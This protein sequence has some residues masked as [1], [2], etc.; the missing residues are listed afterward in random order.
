MLTRRDFLKAAAAGGAGLAAMGLVGCSSSSSS[1]SSTSSSDS[2]SESTGSTEEASNATGLSA[3]PSSD[4]Y[5]GET[6]QQT[7][8]L[9]DEKITLTMWYPIGSSMGTLADLNDGEFWQWYEELTNVHIEFTVPATGSESDAFNLLFASGDMPDI[10]YS[11]PDS[12]TYRGGQDAAIEDG[13]FIDMAE[14]L[15]YAPNYVSWLNSHDEYAKAAYS[16]TGKL[17]GFWGAWQTDE[18]TTYADQGISIRQDFLDAVN[19]EIPT[20]YDEWEEVLAAFRDE[21]G[22]EAPFYTGKYGIDNGEFMAGFDTAPYFYQRDGVVNYGPMDDA[23]KEY[24]EMLHRWW[25]EG[26][27]DPDFAT[28]ASTGIMAD[29]DMILNDKVGALVD[30]GT[31]MGSTY[32]TRGATNENFNAVAALQPKM[33]ADSVDP[34]WRYIAVGSERMTGQA[35]SISADCEYLETAIRWVDGFYGQDV[36]LNANYGIDSEEGIVWYADETDGHRIGNYDFRY[37][38]PDGIDSATVLVQYWTKN[39][40]VR[41]EA[42]QI[43]Q[44]DETKQASYDTWRT[45][46][47]VNVLPTRLTMTS[48]EGT[49]YSTLYADIETYVQESNVKFIMGQMSLDDYD[50]YRDTLTTMGI[51]ECIELQQAALD[52]YNARS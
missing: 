5:E 30:Y 11:Q 24:L 22:I 9:V 10:V 20:T 35:I 44:L 6:N 41:V 46:E 4:V 43:E 50:T 40:P 51:E 29:N 45:Y 39:P 15:D 38:N 19:M 23:Y 52:R 26:L 48:D 7:Y 28:R 49:R 27:L 18:D 8:P 17:Y 12:Q 37:S 13:Y 31:R 42:S 36:Y 25:E 14:Y 33:S 16:D 1:T 34:A 47:P 2:S 3:L 32:V 21:L